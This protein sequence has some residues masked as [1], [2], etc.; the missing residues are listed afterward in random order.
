VF[1][2]ISRK[3]YDELITEHPPTEAQ[4]AAAKAEGNEGLNWNPDTYP[5][6]L[7]SECCIEPQMDPE[8]LVAWLKGDEWNS[9]EVLELFSACISVNQ[10]R[11]VVDLGK[12]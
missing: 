1:K 6:A 8:T 10:S 9:S 3:R 11:R 4:R 12:G 7:I 5:E 2:N